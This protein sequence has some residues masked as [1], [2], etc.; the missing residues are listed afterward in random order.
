VWFDLCGKAKQACVVLECGEGVSTSVA[1]EGKVFMG[2]WFL[3][4]CQR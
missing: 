1:R 2:G 3:V 4:G